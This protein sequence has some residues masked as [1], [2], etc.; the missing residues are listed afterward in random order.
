MA[1]KDLNNGD[2]LNGRGL[3]LGTT[4]Y[5]IVDGKLVMR[6]LTVLT[7]TLDGKADL[8][9]HLEALKKKRAFLAGEIDKLQ[10]LKTQFVALGGRVDP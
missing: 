1:L 7:Q 9:E 2:K 10:E 5:E 3:S 6:V 8:A 4:E